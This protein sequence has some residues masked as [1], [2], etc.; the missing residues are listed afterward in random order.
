M[1]TNAAPLSD[2][3]RRLLERVLRGEVARQTWEAAIERSSP[4]KSIPLAPSQGQIWLHSQIASQP[5]Y[6]QRL[7]IAFRGS[8]NIDALRSSLHQLIRRHQILRTTF[9]S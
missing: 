1:T 3:K 5:I 6:N 4:G 8:L 2:A 7:T 9:A